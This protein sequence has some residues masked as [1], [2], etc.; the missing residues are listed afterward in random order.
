MK[1]S[2]KEF[3]PYPLALKMKALGFDEPC[4]GCYTK[5]KELSYDYSDN[6]GEGHYF[7]DCAAPTF[8]QAFRW[9]RKK[10]SLHSEI[11]W[12]H[13]EQVIWYYAISNID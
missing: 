11:I 5:D 12:D 7:Q 10:Y 9:F 4:F 13:S 3:V 2:E 1:K 6:R 8:S